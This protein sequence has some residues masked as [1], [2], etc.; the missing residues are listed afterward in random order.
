MEVSLHSRQEEVFYDDSRYK[1]VAAGR[2]FGKT[3]LAA[4]TLFIEASRNTVVRT[5]GV[6]IDLALEKVYY[7]AP[8]FTQGKE[9]LWPVLKELG[10]DLIAQAYENEAS[11]RLINGRTIHIKGADRPDS[12]RGTG[13]SYVV[14]DEN[15]A[16]VYGIFHRFYI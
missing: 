15:G 4:V 6:E 3:F 16:S 12:L 10:S 8:T 14:L 5:D 11:V 7:V 1:V 13:L 9:I 2:R